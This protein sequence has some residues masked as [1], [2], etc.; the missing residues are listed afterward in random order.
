VTELVAVG[1]IARAHGVH[2]EVAVEPLSEVEARFEPGSML[3][4]EDGRTLTV[5][6]ARPHHH[7]LLVT[8][9]EI[10]DR[11]GAEALRGALLL[12]PATDLPPI[13]E[14][15]KYWVHQV[16]GLE[17]VTE[18]GRALGRI[19]EVHGNPANDLWV[20]ETG[21]IIPALRDVVASVDLDAGLVTIRE[22]PGLLE[23][24]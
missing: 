21:A 18:D 1:R 19:R 14:A 8:F 7:R 2:G 11:D 17:V 9:D 5:R 22:V 6:G 4:L 12:V 20:T 10:S 15:D 3:R 24:A 23:E 16:V 13:A